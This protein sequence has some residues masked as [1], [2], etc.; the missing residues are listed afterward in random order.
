[1]NFGE[2]PYE[3]KVGGKRYLLPKNGFAVKGPKV[4]Q[5]LALENGK[6]VTRIQGVPTP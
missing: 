5:S 2:Q 1:V 6:P 4:E 3:A